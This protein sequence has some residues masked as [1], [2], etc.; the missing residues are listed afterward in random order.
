[1]TKAGSIQG[2]VS[3]ERILE[4]LRRHWGYD[5]LR[6]HQEEAVRASLEGQDSLVVL[7]TGGGK[8]LCYQLPAAIHGGT[9][10][11]VSPLISLMKDQVD[12]LLACG[13]PACALHS[14]LSEQENAEA[15]RAIAAGEMRLVYAAPERVLAPRTTRLLREAGIRSIVIDE[16][17]CISH[18]GHDFRPE[19]RRLTDLRRA[20]PHAAWHAFT[21]TATERV[22]ADIAD[23]LGIAGGR[24]LVG[25]CDRPNLT[26]RIA[27]RTDARSQLL[28]AI[29]RHKGEAVIVYCLSRK[30]TESTADWLKKQGVDAA[31]YH[32]GYDAK[33]RQRIQDRFMQER[34]NVIAATVAFGMGI[35]RSDVRC[36]VH[37]AMPKSIEHYQQEAGRAGRDGLPAECVLLY[38]SADAARWRRLMDRSAAEA[39]EP[40]PPEHQLELLGHMQRFCS[41]MT[42]RHAALARYFGQTLTPPCDGCDVCLGENELD[43]D[44]V[45]STQKILSCV[46]RLDGR[47]GA[48]HVVSVLRGASTEK[49]RRLGHNALS[50]HGLMRQTPTPVLT[51]YIDQLVD[52]GALGRTEDE[53]PIVHLT[54][55]SRDFLRGERAVELRRP[56][57]A[58]VLT[59]HRR[60]DEAD[61][62]G[63]DHALFEQLRELRRT[64][65]EERGVPAYI[66][67]GDQTLRELARHKPR[68]RLELLRLKGV[69]QKKLDE[70]GDAFLSRIAAASG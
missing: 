31:A 48:A 55:A 8:S 66:V 33:K 40:G 30:D 59:T 35:D 45:V 28:E 38:S 52:A 32:A 20:F 63:V 41:G 19:Y 60:R 46:A 56:K 16:A 50:V 18:W 11:V 23:Q 2:S 12:G 43:A 39:G 54:N 5:A 51:S 69:G 17:H 68:T 65:A 37:L 36:V 24:V 58:A 29:A 21:A 9:D 22:R 15:E 53:R 13:V 64:I 61:W 47:F 44:A 7:P 34:C 1:M 4:V 42:C 10:L 6:P 49:I 14:G 27:P 25:E 70:F 62:D 57:A 26:Y 3:A 67:F